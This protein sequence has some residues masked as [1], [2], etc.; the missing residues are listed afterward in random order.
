MGLVSPL[1]LLSSY[2]LFPYITVP[3]PRP[4]RSSESRYKRV[5]S[6]AFAHPFKGCAMAI[7]TTQ[8]VAGW[9]ELMPDFLQKTPGTCS[10]D[11]A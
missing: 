8:Q 9:C 7:H 1:G 6:P 10:A 4:I 11:P 2:R 5:R 3:C